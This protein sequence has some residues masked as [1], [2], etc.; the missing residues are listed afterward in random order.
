[1]ANTIDPKGGWSAR[2]PEFQGMTDVA[3]S[4]GSVL[5]PISP[6]QGDAGQTVEYQKLA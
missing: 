2:F 6:A 1:M 5:S 4:V 3:G